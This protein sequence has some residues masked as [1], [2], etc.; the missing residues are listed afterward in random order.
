MVRFRYAETRR[1]QR[2]CRPHIPSFPV[3][4]SLRSR[5]NSKYCRTFSRSV[6]LRTGTPSESRSKIFAPRMPS[7]NGECVAITET[8]RFQPSAAQIPTDCSN[9]DGHPPARSIYSRVIDPPPHRSKLFFPFTSIVPIHVL[10]YGMRA[11]MSGMMS[12]PRDRAVYEKSGAGCLCLTQSHR[13][14]RTAYPPRRRKREGRACRG[15]RDAVRPTR[16]AGMDEAG[17]PM[18]PYPMMDK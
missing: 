10:D 18:S 4:S 6:H 15:R 1:T 2:G 17:Y 7:R 5:K 3:N 12:T 11:R 14:G 8:Y 16:R 9:S 13:D